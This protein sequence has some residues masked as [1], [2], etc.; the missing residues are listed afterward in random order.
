MNLSERVY[1]FGSNS[2]QNGD[3]DVT[4]GKF[5]AK[6]LKRDRGDVTV[7][8]KNSRKRASKIRLSQP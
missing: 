7:G 4:V 1:Q 5:D 2:I 8:T 3:Y 6:T